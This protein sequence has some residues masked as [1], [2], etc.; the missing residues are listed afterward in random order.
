MLNLW[1]YCP[2]QYNYFF[3][4][5]KSILGA[6][7]LYNF[8]SILHFFYLCRKYNAVSNTK[9]TFYLWTTI[10]IAV[11]RL[12]LEWLSILSYNSLTCCDMLAYIFLWD[13]PKISQEILFLKK[14]KKTFFFSFSFSYHFLYTTLYRILVKWSR[15]IIES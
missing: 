1:K 15:I 3:L 4:H 14:K 6:L 10:G 13:R 5:M 9:L 11:S 2:V 7:E 12:G 8:V